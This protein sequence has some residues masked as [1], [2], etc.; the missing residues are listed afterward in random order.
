[1]TPLHHDRISSSACPHERVN[2]CRFSIRFDTQVPK[3]SLEVDLEDHE[4]LETPEDRTALCLT[5]VYDAYYRSPC[6]S[7]DDNSDLPPVGGKSKLQMEAWAKKAPTESALLVETETE[8][9]DRGANPVLDL[10][11]LAILEF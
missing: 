8:T 2:F 4:I 6:T 3:P 5:E 1:M 9:L 10:L 11:L 7:D